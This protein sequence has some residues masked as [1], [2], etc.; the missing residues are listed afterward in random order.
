MNW[1]IIEL[2]ILWRM[3]PPPVFEQHIAV[4]GGSGSGKTVL[5]SSFYGASQDRQL[6][7]D[8]FFDIV[9]ENVGQASLLHQNYLEMKKDAVAPE[10]TLFAAEPYSFKIRLKESDTGRSHNRQHFEA[11]RLVWHD[12]PGEWFERDVQSPTEAVRRT[13]TFK[14]LLQSDVALLLVD[15]QKL[16]EYKDDEQRYFKALFG[17]FRAGISALKDALLED[18]KPLV[19]FP[20]IWVVALSKADLLPDMDVHEFRDLVIHKAAQELNALRTEIE[21]FIETKDAL[22]VG[23]DF[24]LLSSAKF[25]PNRIEVEERI[26]LDLILPLAAILPLERRVRWEKNLQLPRRVA[27]T[28]LSAAV[29]NL[30]LILTFTKKLP[31]P[32]GR[33]QSLLGAFASTAFIEDAAKL[34]K[35]KLREANKT[36]IERHDYL[37][38]TLTGFKIDLERGEEEGVYLRSER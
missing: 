21:G 8:R 34:A 11:L 27:E 25:E 14:N 1:V 12:Y 3:A 23:E 26:G 20:R 29:P 10:H 38:A 17:S 7:N 28:I 19:K 18:G 24:L 31:G 30:A 16:L 4:F 5:L 35:E 15:G 13:E 9:A 36:A 32:L 33:V 37:A 2:P 22:S 6:Y